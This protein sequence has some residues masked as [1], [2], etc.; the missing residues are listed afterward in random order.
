MELK[1]FVA[2]D[3]SLPHMYV[4]KHR[5]PLHCIMLPMFPPYTETSNISILGQLVLAAQELELLAI[6][7]EKK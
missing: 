4:W 3:F 2:K 7:A 5:Q 1:N 6:I